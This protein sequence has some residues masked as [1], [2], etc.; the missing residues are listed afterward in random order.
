MLTLYK[1]TYF[2]PINL[3]PLAHTVSSW[4]RM[5]PRHNS[6]LEASGGWGLLAQQY[7][8]R[9]LV[10]HWG[11]QPGSLP[12]AAG[13]C[14]HSRKPTTR[15]SAPTGSMGNHPPEKINKYIYIFTENGDFSKCQQ[16]RFWWHC[17]LLL[18]QPG[19]RLNKKDGLT[20][21]GDSHVKDK[22]S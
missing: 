3:Q 10:C 22:T 2:F 18:W 20:R 8:V 7:L 6:P 1:G 19:G 14:N 4:H 15:N 16:C 17:R 5:Q 9:T 11:A 21:Y 12:A 13:L